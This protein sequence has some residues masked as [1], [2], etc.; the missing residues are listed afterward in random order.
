MWGWGAMNPT[1]VKEAAKNNYPMDKFV[2]VWWAGGDDDARRPA[3][4]A[5]GYQDARTSIGVGANFPAIQDIKKHVV[6]K[7]KSQAP[8]DKVGENLYNRGVYNSML[9]AE[10][11]P[12]R[13]ED[14][15]QEGRHRRGRAPRPRDAE[16]HRGALEGDGHAKASPRRSSSPAPTTTAISSVYMQQWDGTKWVKVSDWIAPMKDKVRPLLEAAAK[17]YVS[18][19]RRLAEAHRGCDKAS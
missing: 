4:A 19:E 13:A 5:K 9:I 11:D 15:R 12:Q 2:G 6:D 16:H 18:Q 1:A 14:H 7:G 3:K 10:G 17:D 8:K